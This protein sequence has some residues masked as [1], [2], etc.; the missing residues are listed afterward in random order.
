M[1][2]LLSLPIELLHDILEH[3]RPPPPLEENYDRK[4]SELTV[5]HC[6]HALA[7]TARTRRTLNV[8]AIPRL[9]SLYEAGYQAPIS[10]FVDRISSD[11]IL[12]KGLTSIITYS[13]D[14][15]SPHFKPTPQRRSCYHQWAWEDGSQLR[16]YGIRTRRQLNTDE[17]AQLEIWRLVS[18]APKLEVLRMSHS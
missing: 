11:T 16:P 13:K 15:G 5:R 14:L 8:L 2:S 9:Y 4:Q 7:A 1:S 6:K 3:L 10:A 18:H 12:Q 17:C